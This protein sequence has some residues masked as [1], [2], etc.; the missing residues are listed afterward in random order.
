MSKRKGK[1]YFRNKDSVYCYTMEKHQ[2]DAQEEG[3]S[4]LELFRA[5]P[6]KVDGMFWCRAVE[7][8]GEDGSCGIQC[9]YYEPKNGRSGM[10]RHKSGFHMPGEKVIIKVTPN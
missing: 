4:Q 3:L 1:Y 10:C 5:I 2:L 8:A 6:E 9:K 7:A